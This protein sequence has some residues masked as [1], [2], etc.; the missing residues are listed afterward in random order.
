MIY[1]YALVDSSTLKVI[2]K[3]VSPLAPKKMVNIP[4]T[5]RISNTDTVEH[6]TCFLSRAKKYWDVVKDPLYLV[7]GEQENRR[8]DTDLI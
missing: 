2:G 1:E 7:T 6:G 8:V 5:V 3:H 4:Y